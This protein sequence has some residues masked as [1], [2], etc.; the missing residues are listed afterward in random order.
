MLPVVMMR[1][2]GQT[3]LAHALHDRK[4]GP[5]QIDASVGDGL[6]SAVT[7]VR[8]ATEGRDGVACAE[9]DAGFK[10]GSKLPAI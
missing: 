3:L 8:I 9:K 7:G 4:V 10:R 1:V 5:H 2:A 6:V